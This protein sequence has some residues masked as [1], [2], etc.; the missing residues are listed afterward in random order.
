MPAFRDTDRGT[1]HNGGE[2]QKFAHFFRP[3]KGISQN[4]PAKNLQYNEK[5]ESGAGKENN[6]FQAT[7]VGVPKFFHTRFPVLT[8]L[9]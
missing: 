2:K 9:S 8:V 5:N 7:I 1:E 3:G 4:I 6:A